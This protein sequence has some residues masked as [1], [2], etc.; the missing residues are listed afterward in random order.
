MIHDFEAYIAKLNFKI[1]DLRR[2]ILHI[3]WEAHSPLKAY[4]ILDRLRKIRPNAEPPTAYRVLDFL[5]LQQI[6][7]RL[8]NSQSYLLCHNHEKHEVAK[9][10]IM[11]CKKCNDTIELSNQLLQNLLT[12]IAA[13]Y[14]FTLNNN[15]VELTG[16]CKNCQ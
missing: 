13:S 16:T 11:L 8:D 10:I 14:Q 1:T 5:V 4:E 2:D 3:L 15:I 9:Q 7:H 12:E 6:I